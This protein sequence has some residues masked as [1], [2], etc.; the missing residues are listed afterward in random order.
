MI[1]MLLH[2]LILL[3]QYFHLI[4]KFQETGLSLVRLIIV[5]LNSMMTYLILR[6]YLLSLISMVNILVYY[7]LIQ[8]NQ[9]MILVV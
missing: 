2:G 1:S 6:L 9:N 4:I 3:Q 8:Q 5:E 7:L